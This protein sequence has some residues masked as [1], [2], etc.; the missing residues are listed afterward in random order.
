MTKAYHRAKVLMKARDTYGNKNQIL[1]AVEELMELGAVLAKYPRYDKHDLAMHAI[2][3]HVLEEVA[4]V[5]IVLEHVREIFELTPDEI[6]RVKD[7]KIARLERW[8]IA[9]NSMHQTTEDRSLDQSEEAR[10]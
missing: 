10:G 5:E 6:D 2:R 7:A 8:L 3:E 1:V 4:D 9:S